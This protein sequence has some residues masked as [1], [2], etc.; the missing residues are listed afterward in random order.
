M[1]PTIRFPNILI[2]ETD[3]GFEG[4]AALKLKSI[5]KG[6]L[7]LDQY[8]SREEKVPSLNRLDPR[9][10]HQGWEALLHAFSS[11][12]ESLCLE[13][14]LTALPDLVFR[15]KGRLLITLFLR[16]IA[17]TEEG[18]K[19]EIISRFLT[20]MPLLGAHIPEADFGP[21]T[22]DNELAHIRAPFNPTH[23]LTVQRKEEV[24]SLSTPLT[25]LS[26]GFGPMVVKKGEGANAVTHIF[27]WVPSMNDWSR[28]MVTLMG[29][30][31]PI[32]IIIRLKTASAKGSSLYR[33]KETIDT[34]EMFLS[35]T[36]EYQVTL[37]RQ[38]GLIR[39]LSLMRLARCREHCFNLGVFIVAPH[40]IDRSLG[41]VLGRAI[42]GPQSATDEDNLF[43]G[44]FALADISETDALNRDYFADQEPFTLT[45]AAC[46][47]RL[48]SP[49]M[50]DH[51]GLP[52]K[53]WRTSLALL[54]ATKAS[55][56]NGIDLVVNEHQGMVQPVSVNMEDRMRHTFILGQTGTGKSTLMES[57]ILQDMRA[58]R[59]LAVIDPHGE[60]VDSILGRIPEKRIDDVILFD[61][62]DREMPLGFNL[63][64]WKTIEERD[65]IIDE[66]YLTLDRLYDMKSVGGPIF[67][68][69]FRGMLKLLMGEKAR[70]DF[71]PTLLEFTACYLSKD[72]R[73]WLQR[74]IRDGQIQDFVK[75]LERTGGDASIQNLSPYITCKFS[76]FTYDI[77]LKRIIGQEK[78]SFDFDEI[79]NEG[80]I[81]LV[82][83]G[84]GRFG[85]T[86][87][88]LLANQIVARFKLAAMKRG[89]MRPEER[90]DF[91]LY[92]DECHNLPSE[93]FMELLSEARKFRMGLV[94]ATQYTAQLSS[95]SSKENN[96]LSAILGNVGTIL[97]FRLGQED[98]ARLSPALNPH[99]SSRD[100]TGLP[101]WQGYA[102]LQ[103]S[104]E[105]TP[106][107]SFRTQKDETPY[108][109]KLA[110]KVKNMS[111][112]IYGTN[113]QE[114][115][116]Q[117][118]RRR[119][120]W[121]EEET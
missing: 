90:R 99:F 26:V 21:V 97:I 51:L 36:K 102:R 8:G 18:V 83:L 96:L 60:M 23:A 87:S 25:R 120:L 98:A 46:A 27:P 112:F 24:I 75:E 62:L 28:L 22:D 95:A 61:T 72:F 118:L 84:K 56:N 78:T 59:G 20:L 11:W 63:I 101:N 114:V 116:A 4:V 10:Q 48:P 93:N 71:I 108:D 74:S 111:R 64:E 106:P 1:K 54:P 86:V 5:L 32:Q 81:L 82:K 45:E 69:H 113:Y 109:E 121:E 77:T 80:K 3:E 107:F 49:P 37:N 16:A 92:V 117:I 50:E 9:V 100:I 33:L 17:P 6:D 110:T 14:H 19:E 2:S 119:S 58:G 39:D 40:P 42:T 76:R 7:L 85:A 88:A 65:L 38:A 94:L 30:L 43:Q 35:G 53:R 105:A 47:F 79:M 34:C 12:P 103:M 13:L 66:I 68:T 15:P 91:F 52:V 57:M 70:D 44:G 55:T 104:N 67:E 115:D 41:N 31:D 73:R 89:D 29:Q